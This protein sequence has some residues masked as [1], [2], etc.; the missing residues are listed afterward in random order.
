MNDQPKI[1]YS[2]YN[3]A[4]RTIMN[5]RNQNKYNILIMNFVKVN[6]RHPSQ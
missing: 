4:T 2:F 1:E 5:A 6:N 3:F